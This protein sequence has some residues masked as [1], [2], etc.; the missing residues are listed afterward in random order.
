[1]IHVC[2]PTMFELASFSDYMMS[3]NKLLCW[4]IS[5]GVVSCDTFRTSEHAVIKTH[6]K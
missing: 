2:V 1:M 4:P 3:Y 5:I 6:G